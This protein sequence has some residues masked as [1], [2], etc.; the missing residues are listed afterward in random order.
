MLFR[1]DLGNYY[2][3]NDEGYHYFLR[4]DFGGLC[5]KKIGSEE[6]LEFHIRHEVNPINITHDTG[7]TNF[8][9][10]DSVDGVTPT[11]LDNLR[12]L[13]LELISI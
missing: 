3:T 5:K 2:P 9:T 13:I 10:V 8:F 11:D 12:D 6:G 4:K 7:L 1:S